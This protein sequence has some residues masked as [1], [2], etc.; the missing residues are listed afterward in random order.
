MK[1]SLLTI[2]LIGQS[3]TAFISIGSHGIGIPFRIASSK[4]LNVLPE[5]PSKHDALTNIH[6]ITIVNFHRVLVPFALAITVLLSPLYHNHIPIA[7]AADYGSLTTE[8][9]AVAEAWRIVDNNFIDRTFNHQDWFKTRQDA[10]KK[11]YKSM[12]EANAA[13]E[14]LVSSLGD[15]YTRYLPLNKY[16]SIV[17][18]ATGT[19]AGIGV[20]LSTDPTTHRVVVADVEANSPASK[21]GLKSG[22][23]F[24]Q[25][26]G[27]QMDD[28]TATPDDVAGKIRGLEGSKV[29]MAIQRKDQVLDF[30]LTREPIT[31][32]SVKSYLSDSSNN[33]VGKIG[34][35]KIKNFS[36]TTASLVTEAVNALKQKGATAFVLDLRGN[37]GGL[38]PGGVAT[39]SLFLDSNKPV[40]FVVDKNGVVDSQATLE[41]G[42][43]LDSSLVVFTNGNTASAA[44]VVTAALKENG[45]AKVSM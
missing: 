37:P 43:D 30:I 2:L 38:L 24:V 5:A 45:R 17:D 9:K 42:I 39:A 18:S 27:V 19:L 13:I 7:Q 32:T 11:K 26:D 25:V 34:V 36:G 29:G 31:I 6:P 10:V 44:E 3:A 40:V 14:S 23:V 33:N 12:D 8:Q 41:R 28:G 4:S 21:G 35:I 1:S 20:E 16:K 22:D 15:K